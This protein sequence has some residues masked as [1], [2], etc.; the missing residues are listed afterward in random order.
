MKATAARSFTDRRAFFVKYCL[1]F[2]SEISVG[3]WIFPVFSL[4][5]CSASRLLTVS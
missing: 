3:S 4:F 5:L 2:S 1:I